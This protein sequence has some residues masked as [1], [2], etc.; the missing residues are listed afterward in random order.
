ME[1]LRDHHFG[2]S[3]Y[4]ADEYEKFTFEDR[5]KELLNKSGGNLLKIDIAVY[6]DTQ[7]LIGY[8]ISSISAGLVGEI[9]SIY[10]EDNYR[11]LGIG[12]EL[13]N[14]ALQWIDKNRVKFKRIVVAMGNE[15]LLPF[16]E[17]Y[18]FFPRH[19]VLEQK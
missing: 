6:E 14:R 2:L 4:F 7:W 16:Y 17:R 18:N 3:P 1:K 5:K 15:D 12:N 9:D 11:S 13:M 19:L 10:L 8:C